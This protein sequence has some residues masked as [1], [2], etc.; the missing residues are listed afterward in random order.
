MTCRRSRVP[1]AARSAHQG[2][3]AAPSASR[4]D[5]G[6]SRAWRAD[7]SARQGE[8]L[9]VAGARLRCSA[10]LGATF[11]AAGVPGKREPAVVEGAALRSSRIAGGVAAR[12][13][14]GGE[15]EPGGR[16]GCCPSSVCG[17]TPD[18]PVFRHQHQ[19]GAGAAGR[20]TAHPLA[21]PP[22]AGP[23]QRP[24]LALRG[25]TPAATGTVHPRG[26]RWGR[27]PAGASHRLAPCDGRSG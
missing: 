26:H 15:F 9:G 27:L 21:L 20:L 23:Q 1:V 4:A 3:S 22:A 5:T 17:A 16:H 8:G 10:G 25:R 14:C 24:P 7:S 13:R 18:L 19:R 12:P 11:D 6:E 2:S